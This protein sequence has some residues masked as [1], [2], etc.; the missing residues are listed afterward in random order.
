MK[1]VKVYIATSLDGWI[2]DKEGKIDWLTGFPNPEGTDYGY[3][4]FLATIDTTLIGNST[5]KDILILSEEFPYPD[6]T[7]YV[8]TRNPSLQDTKYVQFVHTPAAE[9]VRELKQGAGA[10]IWLVGGGLLNGSLLEAGLIDEMIIHVM[11][12]ILG[13]GIPL[14]GG[15]NVNTAFELLRHKAYSS[16]VLELHYKKIGQQV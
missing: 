11:P 9:F 15:V 5:Y 6:K 16:G 13:D 3:S 12:V 1:K 10:D 7:N 14:F 2:A 8:F 4:E